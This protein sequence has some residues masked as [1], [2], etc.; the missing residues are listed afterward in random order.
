MTGLKEGAE[1]GARPLRGICA[2]EAAGDEAELRGLRPY[3]FLK[4]FVVSHRRAL[5]PSGPSLSKD[6]L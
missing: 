1:I 6:C 3:C 5:T 4:S 2:S